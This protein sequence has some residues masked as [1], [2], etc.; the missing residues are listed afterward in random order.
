MGIEEDDRDLSS[1]SV[2]CDA[3]RPCPDRCYLTYSA[4]QAAFLRS[5]NTIKFPFIW[6]IYVELILTPERLTIARQVSKDYAKQTTFSYADVTAIAARFGREP[7]CPAS[8][9]SLQDSGLLNIENIILFSFEKGS[10]SP[11]M[12]V[13][14]AHQRGN[15]V[16]AITAESAENV[17][18]TLEDR[19]VGNQEEAKAVTSLHA[20]YL[21]LENA[22]IIHMA[23][24]A[25]SEIREPM[26]SEHLIGANS[27]FVPRDDVAGNNITYTNAVIIANVLGLIPIESENFEKLKATKFQRLVDAVILL[28][29]MGATG[30]RD[31]TIGDEA[32][33]L[34]LDA[35]VQE[36][37][38]DP[39]AQNEVSILERGGAD[40][41]DPDSRVTTNQA[42]LTLLFRIFASQDFVPPSFTGC[43]DWMEIAAVLTPQ[44]LSD[45]VRL[46]NTFACAE[47]GKVSPDDAKK[48]A[49]AL[50]LEIPISE[51][52][53]NAL[54]NTWDKLTLSNV[55]LLT[56]IKKHF[57]PQGDIIE[58]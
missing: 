38:V 24:G 49:T 26:E 56:L 16:P 47:A 39:F 58:K 51:F 37:I 1:R 42:N 19:L 5:E 54:D 31:I 22:G 15:E 9:K 20:V 57:F 12:R 46:M 53:L 23:P 44:E 13:Q 36:P 27:L 43:H 7:M 45:A 25:W 32:P 55:I 14:R 33:R 50:G 10:L 30:T 8:F 35:V 11:T 29:L 2:I 18:A 17:A 6:G 3:G 4:L 40:L 41:S 21:E 28:T 34:P 52:T 48:I